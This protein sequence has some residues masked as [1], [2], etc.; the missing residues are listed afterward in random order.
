MYRNE[1]T[2]FPTMDKLVLTTIIFLY[3]WVSSS[4]G[5]F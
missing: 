4:N 3:D 1:G 5:N 2:K